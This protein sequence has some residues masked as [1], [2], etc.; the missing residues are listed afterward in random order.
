MCLLRKM[1]LGYGNVQLACH[2]NELF[3]RLTSLSEVDNAEIEA[4][5]VENA[6]FTI[7]EEY[8]RCSSPRPCTRDVLS[9]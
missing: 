5:E 4:I 1:K 8:V 2:G 6:C 9:N 7:R 3:R